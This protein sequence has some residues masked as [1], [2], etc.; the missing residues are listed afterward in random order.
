MAGPKLFAENQSDG[1]NPHDDLGWQESANLIINHVKHGEKLAREFGVPEVIVDL[2]SQHHGTQLVEYFYNK[3]FENSQGLECDEEDF[4][5]PGPKPQS[6]EAAILMIVDTAEA[7]SRS[8]HEPTREKVD[9]MSRRLIVKRIDDGQFDE[10]NLSTRNLAKIVKT[11]LDS[12]EASL[13][14]RVP[15]PWQE[16][17]K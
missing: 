5:Y 1:E 12:L 11:L 13:H 6:V 16:K 2:I 14:S 17:K 8:M 15:Y 9:K 3:A 7:A 10:C 4:R